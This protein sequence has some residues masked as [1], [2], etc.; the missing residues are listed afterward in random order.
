[1]KIIFLIL[2]TLILL[3]N[4]P[5]L[6]GYTYELS[7]KITGDAKGRILIIFPYRVFYTSNASLLFSVTPDAKGDTLFKLTGVEKTGFMMRTLGFSGRSLAIL[8]ADNSKARG[9]GKS[10]RLKKEF[11]LRVHE[12]SKL[13][14][15][16]AT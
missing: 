6:T 3:S 11:Q 14:D 12:Y 8:T 9:K 7:Y 16:G 13:H 10:T 4:P 2:I 1:M 15:A 5:T